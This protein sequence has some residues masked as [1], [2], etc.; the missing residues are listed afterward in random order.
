M[1]DE[2]TITEGEFEHIV[3]EGTPYQVG[4]MQGEVL[5]QK[6]E[7]AAGSFGSSDLRPE[8]R[9]FK[10][11]AGVQELY[12]KCCP[13]INDEIQGFADSLGVSPEKVFY[14]RDCYSVAGNCSQMVALA[15]TTGDGHVYVGRSYETSLEGAELRL[16]TTRIKGKAHH[17]G[18]SSLLFG[19]KDGINHHGLSVTMSGAFSAGMPWEWP[20]DR[21]FDYP[22]VVRSLL[23]HCATVSEAL[24]FLQGMPTH[25]YINLIVADRSSHAALVESAGYRRAVKQISGSTDDG[26]L[27]ATNHYT[28]S[29]LIEHNTN[30][31]TMGHSVPRYEFI[32]SCLETSMPNVD[33]ETLRRILTTEHAPGCCFPYYAYGMGTLWSM[34]LD[35]T[36][37]HAEVCF[38]APTHNEWRLFTLDGPVGVTRY[39]ARF[40]DKKG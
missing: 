11:F 30:D 39:R 4:R 25:L 20:T 28:T 14:Y 31:A 21:G 33:K 7:Q 16:C 15:P 34:I 6:D 13:G 19:R 9:G 40:P 38:G 17:V 36:A 37:G 24:E 18:F 27:V 35:L 10:D 29:D 2:Y 23:D 3:L 1:S 12:E 5:K 22:I 32:R 8:E 26:Y